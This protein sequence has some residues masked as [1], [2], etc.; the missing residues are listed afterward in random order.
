MNAE[1]R[2]CQPGDAPALCEIYNHYV[3]E[4]HVTFE[5]KPVEEAEMRRRIQEV[6]RRYP[7]L[8]YERAG[9]VLAFTHLSCWN[10][11]S[12]Y[13]HTAESSIYLDRSETGHGIG[14]ELYGALLKNAEDASLHTLIG[15]IALP[16]DAS[17]ALHEKL[18]F[19]KAG[20]FVEVGRKFDRWVD[21]G[22]WSLALS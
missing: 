13:L 6:T 1:I 10:P 19:E 14:T 18:G 11:R 15:V 16:N 7:W 17:V 20:H 8:V 3:L 4:T 2:S 21:V 22:Y 12:A 9:R 5:S